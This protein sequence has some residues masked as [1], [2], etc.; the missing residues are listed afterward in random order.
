MYKV[1][2]FSYSCKNDKGNLLLYNTLVGT[3]SFCKLK[4]I[5]VDSINDET[6]LNKISKKEALGLEEKG[7]IVDDSLDE[8]SILNEIILQTVSPSTLT[9]F[10]NPTESC[11]F[12]CKYCY[13]N[14]TSGVMQSETQ[15]E[16][17]RTIRDN[18][19][20]YTALHV[21][22]FGGEP[23]LYLDCIEYLTNNF[24]KICR[25]NKRLYS[26]S[27]TTNGYLLSPNVFNRLLDLSVKSYQITLDGVEKTHDTYRVMCG[28]LPTYN[29]IYSNINK[30]KKAD[31]RH[32]LGI[33]LQDT[34]LFTGTVMENIR[35]GNLDACDEECIAAA[36]LAGAD[37]F[38]RRLPEGYNTMLHGNGANLSQGQ[39]QLLAI[40]RAAVAD[41]PVMILDEATSSIDTRTEAIVQQGMDSLMYGRT[42]FVIAHRLSTVRN[43]NAIM[44]LDHGRIVERGDHDDLIRQHGLYYQLYTGAFELE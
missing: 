27:I 13:E 36:Q 44:V 11:N 5:D 20:H 12:R 33:V 7:I 43:S 41:P 2:R 3:K 16:I 29:Q 35:Y 21:S 9:I 4:Y 6:F 14:H 17:I 31:L 1:S 38:I 24:K 8:D 37:D 15:D 18:I 22:W 34:H 40:A 25:F 23:L 30:I 10:I 28:G 39:R 32:S 19:H 42:V 26:A